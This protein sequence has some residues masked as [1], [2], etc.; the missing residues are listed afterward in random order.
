MKRTYRFVQPSGTVVCAIPGKGEIELP[1]VQGILKHASRESLFDLLKDPD[2][3][4]KYTLEA[5]RVAPWSALQH[6]PREWLK[7]CL[8][9]A[10]L[11]E[12]RARAVEFMLS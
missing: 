4:L 9:K 2:I 7:E 5:L 3:A 8:P 12:G 11:R 10:D 1:V 6:F